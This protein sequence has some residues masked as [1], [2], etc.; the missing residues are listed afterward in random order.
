MYRLEV[1]IITIQI[2]LGKRIQ[3]LRKQRGLSQEKFALL[4]GMDRTYYASVE[5]GKRNISIRNI[6]KIANGLNISL[7]ELFDGVE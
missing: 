5:A 3:N 1:S 6:Q 7:S 4:I 2:A